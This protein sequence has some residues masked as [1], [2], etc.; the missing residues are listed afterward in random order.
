MDNKIIAFD[1]DGVWTEDPEA[2]SSIYDF[3]TARGHTCIIVTG[4]QQP[5]GKLDRLNLQF[6]VIIVSER[7]LK[8]VAARAAG[9][10]VDIWIDDHPEYINPPPL[11][12]NLL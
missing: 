4:A 10:E 12:D 8:S 2:F 7:Q 11:E 1:I 6:K 9:Y 5:Q 3:L